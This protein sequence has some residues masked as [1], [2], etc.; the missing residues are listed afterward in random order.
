[1]PGYVVSS[2][3]IGSDGTIYVGAFDAKLY[4]LDPSTGAIRWSFA[5]TDHIYASPALGRDRAGRTDGI[6][7]ASADGSVYALAPDG[8]L[9]WRYDTGAPIRSSPV[10]GRAPGPGHQ[11]D[12]LRRLLQRDP[13]RAR[14]RHRPAAL[15]L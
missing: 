8:R 4:A 14:R 9:R 13:L 6:Y 5:T 1:M 12:R 10:I 3:A 2:P 15:V 7:V 11:R